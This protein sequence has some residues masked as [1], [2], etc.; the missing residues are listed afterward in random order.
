MKRAQLLN[1]LKKHGCII[2]RNGSNHDIYQNPVTGKYL[3]L[4]DMLN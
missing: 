2:L 1:H 3:Q 4:E